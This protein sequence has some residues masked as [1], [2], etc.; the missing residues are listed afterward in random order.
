MIEFN[1]SE[2]AFQALDEQFAQN[3]PDPDLQ[4]ILDVIDG[5]GFTGE[6]TQLIVSVFRR[7]QEVLAIT[8]KKPHLQIRAPDHA[9]L[10]RAILLHLEGGVDNPRPTRRIDI[11]V[12]N[13]AGELD[14]YASTYISQLQQQEIIT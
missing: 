1:V 9:I 8:P 6:S 13:L 3:E 2:Q 14:E 7:I 11:Y 10:R 5:A 12:S 4:P